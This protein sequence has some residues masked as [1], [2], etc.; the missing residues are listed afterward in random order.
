MV[1]WVV[2]ALLDPR[3]D[4]VRYIGYTPAKRRKI[5]LREHIYS[6]KRSRTHTACLWEREHGIFEPVWNRRALSACRKLSEAHQNPSEATRQKLRDA[7]LARS[8]EERAAFARNQCGVPKSE[9]HK[10]RISKAL[11]EAW[12]RRKAHG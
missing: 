4:E 3:T 9:T 6:A 1:D 5:R 10:Q 2:Y 7:V 8:S 12:A 11:K